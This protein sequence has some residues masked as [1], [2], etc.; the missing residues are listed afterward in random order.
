M[1]EN[2]TLSKAIEDAKLNR[3]QRPDWLKPEHTCHFDCVRPDCVRETRER[4]FMVTR[5]LAEWR[6]FAEDSFVTA[7]A[8]AFGML[9]HLK[10][11]TQEVLKP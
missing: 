1:T 2:Y 8:S 5:L 6:A 3:E 7:N 10:A 11:R 4:L 9:E